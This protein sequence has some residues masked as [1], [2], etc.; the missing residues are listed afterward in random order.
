MHH[1][2]CGSGPKVSSIKRHQVSSH[3]P[4]SVKDSK[5][6]A[7]LVVSPP[8]QKTILLMAFGKCINKALVETLGLELAGCMHSY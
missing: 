5:L 1:R 2:Q 8:Y 4:A 3:G 6:P 7:V